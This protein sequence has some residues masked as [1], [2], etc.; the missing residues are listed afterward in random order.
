M[1][2]HW[3]HTPFVLRASIM[4]IGAWEGLLMSSGELS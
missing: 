2:R 4:L 3:S 1:E